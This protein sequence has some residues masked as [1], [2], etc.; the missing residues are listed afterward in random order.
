MAKLTPEEVAAA[1]ARTAGLV[2]EGRLGTWMDE[3]G[4][5]GKG[6]PV[7]VSFIS[8]GASNE[9]FRITRG[10]FVSV[11][12]RPPRVVPKGRNETMLREYRVLEALNGTDVPHPEAYAGVRRRQRDGIELLSDERGRRLVADEHRRMARSLRHRP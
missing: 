6:E 9:I 2:D 12:R 5:P 7:S 1:E 3:R 10:D 4:L 8:G 11:L